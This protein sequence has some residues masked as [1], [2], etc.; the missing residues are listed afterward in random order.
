MKKLAVVF[1]MLLT[2]GL[3]LTSC[4]AKGPAYNPMTEADLDD[5]AWLKGTWQV[6]VS[7]DSEY[8]SELAALYGEEVEEGAEEAEKLYLKSIGADEKGKLVIDDDN[9]DYYVSRMRYWLEGVGS[10][11]DSKEFMGIKS[12][13]S[14]EVALE[15]TEAKDNVRYF[16]SNSGTVSYAGASYSVSESEEVTFTKQ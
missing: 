15:V 11:S 14:Y 8:P 4:G 2:F 3:L 7:L 13:Y 5:A 6:E 10:G 16:S 1:G 9:V 12:E